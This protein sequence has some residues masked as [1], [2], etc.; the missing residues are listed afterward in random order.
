M[1]HQS[2]GPGVCISSTSHI[3]H[4][5]M[6]A[7]K[8]KLPA[9]VPVTMEAWAMGWWITWMAVWTTMGSIRWTRWVVCSKTVCMV[10]K[11]ECTVV[12]ITIIW[13]IVI[14]WATRWC[15]THST[16]IK[17]IITTV[18]WCTSQWWACNSTK[19]MAAPWLE[20]TC[21]EEDQWC[22]A[23]A[24]P[25]KWWIFKAVTIRCNR[26]TMEAIILCRSRWEDLWVTLLK[27]T[28]KLAI[29]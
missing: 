22:T 9:T 12:L 5:C 24:C 18:A 13:V 17:I 29:I 4:T 1:S 27:L 14:I 10:E 3:N 6:E 21:E 8:V 25:P 26:C 28:K 16:H 2:T 11:W 19:C 15:L 23:T 7:I 20:V